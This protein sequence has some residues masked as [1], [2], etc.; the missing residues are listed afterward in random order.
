MSKIVPIFLV[1]WIQAVVVTGQNFLID[2]LK[3]KAAQETN[4]ES[5]LNY[6]FQISNDYIRKQ[7]HYDSAFIYLKKIK[8]IA[9]KEGIKE[10]EAIVLNNQAMIYQV[11]GDNK[12]AITYFDKGLSV[13]KELNKLSRVALFYNNI[14]MIYK[15][16]EQH[17]KSLT[18]LDSAL[19]IVKKEPSK[20][21]LG[22]VYTSLG[23]TNFANNSFKESTYYLKKGIHILDSIKQPSS[24]ADLVLAK[25][26]RAE[27]KLD[28]AIIQAQK[29]FQEAQ[30]QKA[31]KSSYESSRLLSSIYAE[32]N[33]TKKEIIYLKKALAYNDSLSLSKDLNDIELNELKEQRSQQEQQLK[34]LKGKD[35][36]YTILYVVGVVILILLIVLLIR[37]LKTAKLTKDI[38]NVQKDL[39]QTELDRRKNNMK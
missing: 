38:H 32:I 13:S 26:Y 6:Y 28:S 39:I 9:N 17:E 10:V 20:R 11:L 12:K 19:T 18:Y 33:D 16:L 7:L 8:T 4:I 36:L 23:E 37:Q 31:P 35:I 1:I 24:E 29:A 15:E 25:S 22:V 14:G 21:L 2:S 34:S 3:I 5:K 27:K 30:Q